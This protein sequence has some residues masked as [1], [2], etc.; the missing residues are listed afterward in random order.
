VIAP[1]LSDPLPAPEIR[2]PCC[3]SMA[4]AEALRCDAC[5]QILPR[6]KARARSSRSDGDEATRGL[7]GADGS[8]PD[9]GSSEISHVVEELQHDRTP[10]G[11]VVRSYDTS[12]GGFVIEVEPDLRPGFKIDFEAA[13]S[14][15]EQRLVR[16]AEDTPSAALIDPS[17]EI[18]PDGGLAATRTYLGTEPAPSA[19]E[20]DEPAETR[21]FV[22]EEIAKRD[23]ARVNEAPPETEA[24]DK[25]T[26]DPFTRKRWVRPS[27]PRAACDEEDGEQVS[28]IFAITAGSTKAKHFCE[29]TKRAR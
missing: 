2:C 9:F 10:D 29:N 19:S 5:G 23:R 28:G 16:T 21:T 11:R 4:P 22:A 25:S 7:L 24:D 26:G 27:H 18:D 17:T 3:A 12:K 15:T 20:D 1:E 6:R 8:N 13:P 14:G